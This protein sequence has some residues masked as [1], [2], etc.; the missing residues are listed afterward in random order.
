M[1]VPYDCSHA[2]YVP[3]C[4]SNSRIQSETPDSKAKDINSPLCQSLST[5]S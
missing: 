2:Y 4:S 5:F 1:L 3:Y